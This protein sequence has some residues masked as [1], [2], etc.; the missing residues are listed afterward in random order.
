M[1]GALPKLQIYGGDGVLFHQVFHHTNR[2]MSK[3]I[4]YPNYV[5]AVTGNLLLQVPNEVNSVKP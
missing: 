1:A 5:G 2:H 3:N 4:P